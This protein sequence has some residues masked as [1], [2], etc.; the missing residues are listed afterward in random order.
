MFDAYLL[1][2]T[3]PSM[4]DAR[5]AYLAADR[6]RSRRVPRTRPSSGARSPARLRRVGG[7]H[8]RRSTESDT[9]PMPNFAVA[10]P[11]GDGHVRDVGN[12]R[13]APSRRGSTS[14]TT[15]HA[16]RRSPTPI[17]PTTGTGD[18]GNLD[19]TASFVA[20]H[21]RVPDPGEGLRPPPLPQDARRR[22]STISINLQANW[23]S[24]SK[25]A[26]ASGRRR[27][28]RHLIDDT[29]GTNWDAALRMAAGGRP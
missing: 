28:T 24:T 27:P 23:A 20:G 10:E 16:S 18:R 1:M 26:T 14:A 9:D 29:E 3:A 15:R 13:A 25:G 12:E 7:E 6:M 5:D 8:E 21:V 19:A 11:A 4:L 22:A 17:R 2:P